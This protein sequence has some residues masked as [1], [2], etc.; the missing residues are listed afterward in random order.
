MSNSCL[1]FVDPRNSDQPRFEDVH[2]G[3]GRAAGRA[4]NP[5]LPVV[6]ASANGDVTYAMVKSGP[7][8]NPDEVE[9]PNV[10]AVEV[11]V[12]WGRSVLH[13][14]HLSPGKSFYVGEETAKGGSCDYFI[15]A[16]KLGTTR[17]ALVVGTEAQ[18]CVVIPSNANG[19]V[20]VPG[21][22]RMTLELARQH[23]APSSDFLDGR[24]LPLVP[25]VKVRIEV[26]D[27]A[28]QIGAVNAGKP[29]KR[30]LA[31]GVDWS[32]LSYFGLSLGAVG[33][34]MASM[35]FF[36]PSLT[37][38]DDM[39]ISQDQL[40]LMQQYLV[41]AAERERE[42]QPTADV[43]D[44]QADNQEGGTGTRAK[45]EEGAM[46]TPRTSQ[47]KRH[48]AVKGDKNN[49]D[50]HLARIAALR[51]AQDFGMVGML[52]AGL[53]GDPKAPTATF[54]RTDSSG[55][56]EESFQGNLWGDEPG[57]SLGGGGLG[58]SGVGEGGGGR[59]E[60]IGLGEFG[61]LGQGAGLGKGQGIGNGHGIL[62]RG[63]KTRAPRIGGGGTT[64]V[65]GRLPPEVIQRIVR[66]NYG[67]FRMCYEQGLTRNPNLQGRVQVRFAIDREGAVTNVQN[68]GSDL[69]DSAVVSCVVNAYYGLSFPK[70]EGGIVTVV[71][72]VMFQP[73]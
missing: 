68:G 66:Q 72:P 1:S 40:Y 71:Y 47:T 2:H 4:P 21:Q 30:G 22:A 13:V 14:E 29:A 51:E 46:G 62:G 6:E 24:V 56:D 73:G 69:P 60:G 57:D 3:K 50:P 53:A 58:L 23:L 16:E 8:V 10:A 32:I 43:A 65:S 36:S 39:A 31:A 28:F 42:A 44:A 45:A 9:L 7:D 5:F 64:T 19:W 38:L 49:P 33:S 17:M 18:T 26:A 55:V 52:N 63:H 70:P 27:F 37:E 61:G 34:L 12:L 15:P 25:G 11:L 54:G 59:G 41:S 67:R 48:Y 20:E 35:A